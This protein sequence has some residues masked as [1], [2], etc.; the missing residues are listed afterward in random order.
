L[1]TK[2]VAEHKQLTLGREYKIIAMEKC[3]IKFPT[4]PNKN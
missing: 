2:I 4:K 1:E 3:K